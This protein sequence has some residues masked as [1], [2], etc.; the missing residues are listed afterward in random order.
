[1][2]TNEIDFEEQTTDHAQIVAE[3]QA[4]YKKGK[5]VKKEQ[6]EAQASQPSWSPAGQSFRADYADT[7]KKFTINGQ[8]VLESQLQ[9]SLE[10]P[11]FYNFLFMMQKKEL[12]PDPQGPI[13]VGQDHMD[14]DYDALE[15]A[16]GKKCAFCGEVFE[17]G[18]L[19]PKEIGS[20]V[21]YGGNYYHWEHLALW[22]LIKCYGHYKQASEEYFL[23]EE[24]VK[25]LRKIHMRSLS[26]GRLGYT[27][28]GV[29]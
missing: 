24:D 26:W 28:N 18:E 12:E 14:P 15:E 4:D 13:P 2:N 8:L 23:P 29:D 21:T 17:E 27:N 20:I 22:A 25:I 19:S 7:E 9:Q 10:S 3:I 5:P 11:D 6:E 1:M 16:I